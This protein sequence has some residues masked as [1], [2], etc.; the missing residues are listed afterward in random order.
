M[1]PADRPNL[2]NS[3]M[4]HVSENAHEGD[5]FILTEEFIG[6]CKKKVRQK[7]T[8]LRRKFTAGR[9]AIADLARPSPSPKS[10]NTNE[11]KFQE[12]SS[13][14]RTAETES[15]IEIRTSLIKYS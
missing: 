13:K 6:N 10:G 9:S 8:T 12:N 11:R 2:R 3:T 7:T 4:P 14:F 1:R 15:G 5:L